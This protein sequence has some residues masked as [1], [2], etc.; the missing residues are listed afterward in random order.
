MQPIYRK[1]LK[2][3][4][5]V[6]SGAL[7]LLLLVYGIL[8]IPQKQALE[9]IDLQLADKKLEYANAQVAAASE[10]ASNWT[11]QISRLRKMLQ[12]FVVDSNDLEDLTF[13]ISRI[14]ASLQA[15]GFTSRGSA[16]E[17]YSEI[18]N[19]EH[20]AQTQTNIEFTASFVNF[21]TILNALERHKPVIFIDQFTIVKTRKKGQRHQVNM[22]LSVYVKKPADQMQQA[23]RADARNRLVASRSF[24]PDHG[25]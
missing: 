13:D 1:Y 19:C 21:A 6:W 2:I 8:I 12:D 11:G 25:L 22:L 14:A 7:L 10:A 5:F 24:A 20:V 4:A 3:L 15:G 18:P 23:G 17:S 9:A 16:G